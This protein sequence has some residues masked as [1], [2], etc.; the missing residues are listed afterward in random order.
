VQPLLDDYLAFA[1]ADS[2]QADPEWMMQNRPNAEDQV[3]RQRFPQYASKA[4]MPKKM[5]EPGGD[6]DAAVVA[7]L[8]EQ[9]R[10][11]RSNFTAEGRDR[12]RTFRAVAGL[13]D[14]AYLQLELE[15][16]AIRF[17]ARVATSER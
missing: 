6:F 10:K 15:N 4:S 7:W 9:W 2:E 14:S 11:E 1:E 3:R 16:G 8:R 5:T 13:L 12:L 17:Q